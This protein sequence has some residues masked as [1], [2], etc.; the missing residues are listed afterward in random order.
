[1]LHKKGKKEARDTARASVEKEMAKPR[2]AK[3]A[4]IT[5]L[6]LD[7][8]RIPE[9]PSTTMPGTVH[10][11]ILSRRPG[12]PE[13][14]QITVDGRD[15]R[16]RDLRIK[17]TLTDENGDYVRL[18]K[19]AHVLVTVTAELKTPAAAISKN[20]RPTRRGAFGLGFGHHN[21]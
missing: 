3:S 20:S 17:N 18:K 13:E 6:I 7:T 4:R 8:T 14:A 11:I 21:S 16:Y 5:E 2:M 1:M 9:H 19:G 15:H 10:K 12:Q